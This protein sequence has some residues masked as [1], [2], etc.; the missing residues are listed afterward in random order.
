[1]AATALGLNGGKLPCGAA[2]QEWVDRWVAFHVDGVKTAV[3]IRSFGRTSVHSQWEWFGGLRQ[4]GVPVEYYWLPAA[5]HSPVR[6]RERLV[7]QQG[8]VDWFRFWLKGEEDTDPGKRAQYERWRRMKE[9]WQRTGQKESQP[10]RTDV[11]S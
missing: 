4:L 7:S 3:R 11:G 5:A 6:P 1:M 8:T 10:A 9:Q 2:V